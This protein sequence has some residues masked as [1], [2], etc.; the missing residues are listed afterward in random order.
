MPSVTPPTLPAEAIQKEI[1]PRGLEPYDGPRG[2]VSGVVRISGDPPPALAQVTEQIPMGKCKAAAAMYG[3]LFREGAERKLADALVAV[4]EYQG[5][6]PPKT[7]AVELG[8]ADCTFASRTLA[9]SFGQRLDVL[10]KGPEAV[11]PQLLGSETAALLVAMPG[12]SAVPLLPRKPGQYAVV[13]RS[14]PFAQ[15]DVFVLSYPTVAVTGLDGA[16]EIP[17]VP[18][19]DVLVSAVLPSIGQS[20]ERR[21]KVEEGKVTRVELTI[22]FDASK[23]GPRKP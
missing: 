15:V 5:F 1:N 9:V 6:V 10:N 21:I 19:G 2:T 20:A 3:K 17:G 23:Q 22:V 18:T 7:G 11:T 4:T 8:A 14:H 13:D 12:G 16:F